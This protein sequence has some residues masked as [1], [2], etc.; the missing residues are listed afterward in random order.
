MLVAPW[1]LVLVCFTIHIHA[2]IFT[3]M[4]DMENM[5]MYEKKMLTE[6]KSYIQ[7]EEEKV[8]LCFSTSFLF[9]YLKDL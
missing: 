4:A 5:V 1:V 6:L 2:E 3:S 8:R 7:A 9:R